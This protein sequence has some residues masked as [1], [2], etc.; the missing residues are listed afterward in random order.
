MFTLRHSA[1]A[2]AALTVAGA[3]QTTLYTFHGVGSIDKFGYNVTTCG[4]VDGD[5]RSDFI[6]SAP[7]LDIDGRLNNGIVRVHSGATGAVLQEYHGPEDGDEFGYSVDGIGDVDGDGHADYV[8][9]RLVLATRYAGEARVYSGATGSLVRVVHGGS[10]YDYF[11]ISAAGVGD[12]DGDGYDDFAVSAPGKDDNGSSSGEVR[13]FSGHSGVELYDWDGDAGGDQFGWWVA[14]VGDVDADGVPDIACGAPTASL[15]GRSECGLVRVFSG[16]TGAVLH[17]FHGDASGDRLGWCISAAGDLNHDGFADLIAGAYLANDNGTD[18]GMARV[19]SGADGSTLFSFLGDAAGDQFG[20]SVRKAGDVDGDGWDDLL[21]GARFNDQA[22]TDAGMARLFSGQ[23]GA[24]MH[25][26]LGHDAGDQ[27]GFSVGSAGD[28]DG[29][30]YFDV[31][32]GAAFDDTFGTD[33]GVVRVVSFG[34]TGE[35]PRD[36]LLASGCPCSDGHLPRIGISGRAEIGS[37]YSITLRSA[38]PNTIAFVN[39]GIYWN[40]PLGGLAP[41][42]TAVPYPLDF[43]PTLTDSFGAGSVTPIQLIPNDPQFVGVEVYHQWFVLDPTNNPL[44]I[45]TS[46]A[47]KTVLGD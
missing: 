14:G 3:A 6:Y 22:G 17:D 34:G 42:C 41:G 19:Y 15:P 44:G 4:D 35:P 11:G 23:T 2:A 38:L 28:V 40:Q 45:A 33:S 20:W 21:V 47:L 30:G 26:F 24:V 37:T 16:R 39:I 29:D 5:G 36:I 32:L 25:T 7:F 8:I 13:V 10:A 12:V 18:S 31:I 9:T 1:L 43:V 46:S 27:M